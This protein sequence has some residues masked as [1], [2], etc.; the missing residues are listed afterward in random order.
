L[1]EVALVLEY[2]PQIET[3]EERHYAEMPWL[4]R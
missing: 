4:A 1:D 3:F 2:L